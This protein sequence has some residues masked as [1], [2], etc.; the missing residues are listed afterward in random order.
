M[1]KNILEFI[2][3]YVE[4]ISIEIKKLD[5]T[6]LEKAILLLK[7]TNLSFRDLTFIVEDNEYKIGKFIPK[8]AIP[9]VSLKKLNLK[10]PAVIIIL[11]W[12]FSD[13]IIKKI[14]NLCEAPTKI[15]IP[16]PKLKVIDI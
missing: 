9:I 8:T 7:M 3:E 14:K 11:A 5:K 15:I 12:N 10:K 4:D 6:K 2:N 16:L 1:K 13:D